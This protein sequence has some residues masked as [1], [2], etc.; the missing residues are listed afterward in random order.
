MAVKQEGDICYANI[1]LRGR[2]VFFQTTGIKLYFAE[3]SGEV[4]VI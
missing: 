2:D 4:F 3:T 1:D